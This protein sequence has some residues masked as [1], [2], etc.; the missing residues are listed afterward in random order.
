MTVLVPEVLSRGEV[1]D[2][3]RA[4]RESIGDVDEFCRRGAA[5]ELDA[6]EAAKYDRLRD[7]EFLLGE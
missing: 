2:R 7:L 5:Y 3:L 1:E 6:E 4:L